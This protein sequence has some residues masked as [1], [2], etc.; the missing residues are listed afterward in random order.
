MKKKYLAIPFAIPLII[1]TG[2]LFAAFESVAIESVFHK[3]HKVIKSLAPIEDVQSQMDKLAPI[4]LPRI[5][6]TCL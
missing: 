6:P 4:T 1:P 3:P 5:L 2:L